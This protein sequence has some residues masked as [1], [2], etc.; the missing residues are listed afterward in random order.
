MEQF[1]LIFDNESKL[2]E[3]LEYNTIHIFFDDKVSIS[4]KNYLLDLLK[5]KKIVQSV[6]TNIAKEDFILNLP[7]KDEDFVLCVG[8]MQLQSIVKYYSYMHFLPY[9]IIPVGE[10]AEYSF[11]KHAFV[12]DKYF[13]FYECEKPKF[14]YICSSL[15]EVRDLQ[16]LYKIL[17]FKPIWLFE[18]EFSA[19]IFKTTY[20]PI[21]AIMDQI[22]NCKQNIKDIIKIYA[23]LSVLLDQEKTY[24]CLGSEYQLLAFLPDESIIT[25]LIKSTNLLT[26]FYDCLF[27]FDFFRI[28]RDVNRHL[29]FIKQNLNINLIEI[30]KKVMP[31]FSED[32]LT[33]I[34]IKLKAYKPHLFMTL[35][36]AKN[37]FIPS[38]VDLYSNQTDFAL[39]LCANLFAR[40]NILR[41]CLELGYFEEIIKDL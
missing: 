25:G 10:V 31:L 41:V 6:V 12:K 36:I 1:N 30:N 22:K 34:L 26:K 39:P 23:M 13:C 24:N 38:K 40:N 27:K 7:Q 9:G 17:T 2:L 35:E 20:N 19:V 28:S 33:D 37:T 14:A 32:Q 15:F 18:K 5:N 4:Y 29:K 8:G 21:S 16:N 3:N 11:T